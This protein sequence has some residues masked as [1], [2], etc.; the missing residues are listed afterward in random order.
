MTQLVL[1]P[2]KLHHI[3]GT[4]TAWTDELW[5]EALDYLLTHVGTLQ[6]LT[7]YS[8]I[9]RAGEDTVVSLHKVDFLRE[10]RRYPPT[11]L[12]GAFD[13]MRTLRQRTNST[14]S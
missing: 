4:S 10:F 7:M 1:K 14:T 3:I 8:T 12:L 6:A 13:L 2:L 5:N 9:D 11:T